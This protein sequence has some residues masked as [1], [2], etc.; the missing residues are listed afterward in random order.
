VVRTSDLQPIGRRFESRPLRF[1]NDPGQ[2]VHT[3][4]PLFIKQYKLIPAMPMGDGKVIV[5]LGSLWPCV[6]D[7]VIYPCIYGLNG[8]FTF[9]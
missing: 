5:G 7:S 2:V 6:T 1:T 9:T 4:V 3:R 8:I